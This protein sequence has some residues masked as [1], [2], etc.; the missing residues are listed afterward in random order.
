M[1]KSSKNDPFCLIFPQFCLIFIHFG[2]FF[3]ILGHIFSNFPKI[4]SNFFSEKYYFLG[5]HIS[6][7]DQQIC[8]LIWYFF[9]FRATSWFV[10]SCRPAHHIVRPIK[11]LFLF[12]AT[13][14]LGP[15]ISVRDLRP[16]DLSC[17]T[18]NLV[19]VYH[20]PVCPTKVSV[21]HLRVP[22]R[23]VPHFCVPNSPVRTVRSTKVWCFTPQLC[24]EHTHVGRPSPHSCVRHTIV[25]WPRDLRSLEVCSTHFWGSFFAPKVCATHLWGGTE[26]TLVCFRS[27]NTLVCVRRNEYCRASP[28][29]YSFLLPPYHTQ[30]PCLVPRHFT[31]VWSGGSPRGVAPPSEIPRGILRPKM[32][33]G[34]IFKAKF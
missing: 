22:H 21:R 25:V 8:K 16:Q 12:C 30:V 32:S 17:A 28:S 13:S 14:L 20:T 2:P 9:L 24:P 33:R 3:A 18:S 15:K 5:V 6:V 10:V 26:H 19:V 4:L 31:C 34:L 27:S 1:W 29:I 11:F 23:C 7:C